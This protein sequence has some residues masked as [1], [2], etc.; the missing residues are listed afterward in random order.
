MIRALPLCLFLLLGLP[1]VAQTPPEQKPP[2]ESKISS[3]SKLPTLVCVYN[4][5]NYSE[6]ATVCVQKAMM[7][8]CTVDG[9]KATWTTVTDEKLSGRCAKPAPRLSTYQRR[10]IW[11]RRNIAREITPPTDSSPFCFYTN[12]MRYC[13]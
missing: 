4:G 9:T 2:V 6:G 3:E 7:Q 12:G 11:N 5:R 13:E 10:A 8:T 1:A